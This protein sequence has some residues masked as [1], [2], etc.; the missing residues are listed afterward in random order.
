TRR[1]AR[2]SAHQGRRAPAARLALPLAKRTSPMRRC[3]AWGGADSADP[4]SPRSSRRG[5]R[6]RSTTRCRGPSPETATAWPILPRE[7]ASREFGSLHPHRRR[8]RD[9]VERPHAAD[10]GPR[11]LLVRRLALALVALGEARHEEL[12][13]QRRQQHAPG[14][15]HLDDLVVVLEVYHLGDG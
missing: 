2:Q 4:S 11:V 10:A 9:L 6:P 15:A 7:P 3:N 8:R 5:S 12:L 1:A 13:R 14:L